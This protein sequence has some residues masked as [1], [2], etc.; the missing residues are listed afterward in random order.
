MADGEMRLPTTEALVE[1][2]A[3]AAEKMPAG[4][5]AGAQPVITFSAPPLGAVGGTLQ[6]DEATA[7]DGRRFV[8]VMWASPAGCTV[9]DLP[10]ESPDGSAYAEEVGQ[11]IVD[12]ARKLRT[13]VA[14]PRLIVP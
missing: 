9:I 8:R 3:K 4:P 7:A 1:A 13:G 14:R 5:P 6:I 11:A 2:A 12:A 10:V